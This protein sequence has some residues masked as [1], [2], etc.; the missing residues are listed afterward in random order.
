MKVSWGIFCLERL[1]G[2][3]EI[4]CKESAL[5]E[6]R[7]KTDVPGLQA[8]SQV[9]S[10]CRR[11]PPTFQPLLPLITC[12]ITKG[13]SEIALTGREL[14]IELHTSNFFGGRQMSLLS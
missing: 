3:K 4:T 12:G 8:S 10:G 2:K 11:V 5:G 6:T 1:L 9:I 14:L 13:P 7:S